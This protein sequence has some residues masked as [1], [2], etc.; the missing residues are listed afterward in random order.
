MN[1]CVLHLQVTSLVLFFSGSD[2]MIT[3]P[4]PQPLSVSCPV[5]TLRE[6]KWPNRE[7]DNPR[8]SDTKIVHF[9]V[10]MRRSGL[11]VRHVECTR[12]FVILKQDKTF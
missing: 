8:L 6:T 5:D 4:P 3:P 1:A 2:S 7:F 9:H 12:W 11:L 10:F